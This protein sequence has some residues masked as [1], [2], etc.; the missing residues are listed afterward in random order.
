MLEISKR[1]ATIDQTEA[2]PAKAKPRKEAQTSEEVYVEVPNALHP[3]S[4]VARTV[5]EIVG[6]LAVLEAIVNS[7]V[8][9]VGTPP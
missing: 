1:V 7:V 9:P 4:D 8:M 2:T 6:V 5:A 3:T